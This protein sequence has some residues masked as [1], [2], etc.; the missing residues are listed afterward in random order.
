MIDLT[1]LTR[2]AKIDWYTGMTVVH[3]FERDRA[4]RKLLDHIL[5]DG[6]DTEQP[7]SERKLA[8][9][10]QLGRT[11]IR[12]ALKRLTSE[13]LLEVRP[14]R[15]TYVKQLTRQDVDEMYE[16]RMGIEGTAAFL[17]AQRGPTAAFDGFCKKFEQMIDDPT[18]F[19]LADIH[20]T[21]QEFHVEI[22]RAARNG[23]LMEIYE[24]LRIRNHVA[25]GLPR[26]YDH[27]WVCEST[28]EHL[29]ILAAIVAQD[30]EKARKLVCDHLEK[31]RAVR[32]RIFDA[33]STKP[34]SV[35]SGGRA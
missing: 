34:P 28:N 1:L 27:D 21:G 22:F 15:G 16:A 20:Q 3:A 35:A 8:D 5:S 32:S 26:I 19:D 30:P 4:Y 29:D 14:A 23:C 9:S 18:R 31:G 2:E 13:G 11:P 6:F 12:E 10:F 7:L 33:L 24:P 25:L 17:A